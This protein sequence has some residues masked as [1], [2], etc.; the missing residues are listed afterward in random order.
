MTIL[1][2]LKR[3]GNIGLKR[4]VVIDNDFGGQNVHH[5]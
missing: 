4:K 1:R 2:G 3:L 5:G